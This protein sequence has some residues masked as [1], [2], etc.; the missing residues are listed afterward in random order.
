MKAFA[1]VGPGAGALVLLDLPT[2]RAAQELGGAFVG[3]SARVE[4]VSS[5]GALVAVTSDGAVVTSTLSS[6]TSAA[7]AAG[8]SAELVPFSCEAGARFCVGLKGLI[9][10]TGRSGTIGKIALFASVLLGVC[11]GDWTV[12]VAV[13]EGVVGLVESSSEGAPDTD[14]E[15]VCTSGPGCTGSSGTVGR[16]SSSASVIAP[17]S[18]ATGFDCWREGS[19]TCSE[20]SSARFRRLRELRIGNDDSGTENQ[21]S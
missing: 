8:A 21:G 15:S 3:V 5:A 4:A 2:K 18:T 20:E 9:G 19:S 1:I 11:A 6:S 14:G 12:A 16:S 13:E 7:A 17:A 10:R